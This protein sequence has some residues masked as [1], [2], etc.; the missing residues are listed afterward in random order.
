MHGRVRKILPSGTWARSSEGGELLWWILKYSHTRRGGLGCWSSVE[1]RY[2]NTEAALWK[3]FQHPSHTPSQVGGWRLSWLHWIGLRSYRERAFDTRLHASD[4]KRTK[5][6]EITSDGQ[7]AHELCLSLQPLSTG[8][9]CCFLRWLAKWVTPDRRIDPE[10]VLN[11]RP[12]KRRIDLG[13]LFLPDAISRIPVP[14]MIE[15]DQKLVQRAAKNNG[16]K[17]VRSSDQAD[18]TLASGAPPTA[19]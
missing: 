14:R 3:I 6:N 13:I 12:T 16:R 4:A 15:W 5:A 7:L 17:V 19:I 8:G 9:R 2:S 10:H 1:P 11:L 18:H